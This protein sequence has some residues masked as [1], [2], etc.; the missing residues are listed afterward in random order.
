MTVHTSPW[1]W[2]RPLLLSAASGVAVIA[3]WWVFVTTVRGQL[4]DA[5][6]LNGSDIGAWLVRGRANHWLSKVSEAGVAVVMVVVALTALLRR[7]W[8]L[9]LEAAVV[10]A[11]ANLS[12]QVLKYHVL[13]RPRLLEWTNFHNN[14]YPSGHT[15]VA[16]SAV[17]AA[18]LVAPR[19]LRALTA[20]LGAVVMVAFGYGTLA[21]RWHRPSDVV[22]GY[23]VC[24]CWAF[25]ALCVGAAR[26]RLLG[27]TRGELPDRRPVSRWW[28]ALLVVAGLAA[29][30]L[31]AWCGWQVRAVDPREAVHHELFLAYLG[32]SSGISGV[33]ACGMGVLLRLVDLHDAGS[34]QLR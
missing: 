9:A 32:A 16:A 17:V 27:R 1:R 24:L 4:V 3:T 12:T 26:Q 28:P 22:G 7:R 15:T 10:V 21:A 31:A 23:L 13:Y 33:A 19:R 20:V 34:E 6:A 29:L 14:S 18:V 5:L 11:G 8:L 30:G 25:M 2:L